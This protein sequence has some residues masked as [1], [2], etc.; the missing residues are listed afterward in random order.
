M[1]SRPRANYD[2]EA[3]LTQVFS[4]FRLHLGL[5]RVVKPV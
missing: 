1:I 2:R 3:H 5:A 4:R